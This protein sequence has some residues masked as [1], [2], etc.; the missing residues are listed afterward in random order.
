LVG[1]PTITR[2]S[3]DKGWIKNEMRHIENGNR[4]T[5]RL[6]GNSRNS[7]GPGKVLAHPKGQRAKDG[8]SYKKAKLQDTD[9]HKLEHKHEGY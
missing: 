8:H 1:R 3:A 2:G 7:T 4:S 6:P 5:V 9:L